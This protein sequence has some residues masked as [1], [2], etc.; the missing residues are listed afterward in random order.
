MSHFLQLE[1][2]GTIIF[3]QNARIGGAA[4]YGYQYPTNTYAPAIP[5]TLTTYWP[6]T[7]YSAQSSSPKKTP[8][9]IVI[10]PGFMLLV[11]H[12]SGYC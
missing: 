5:Y 6:F 12:D 3:W 1:K 7:Y 2:K 4:I 8:G 9:T 11:L 10:V